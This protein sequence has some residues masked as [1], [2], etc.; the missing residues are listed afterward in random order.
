M[1]ML[2]AE[3]DWKEVCTCRYP[4]LLSAAP[5]GTLLTALIG[6]RNK[7]PLTLVMDPFSS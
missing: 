1:E 3:V 5:A 2:E 7:P 6:L 4:F